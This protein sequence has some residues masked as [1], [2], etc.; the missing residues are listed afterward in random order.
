MSR[1]LTLVI[2]VLIVLCAIAGVAWYKIQ[3]A[4]NR[5]KPRLV[6]YCAT[7]REIVQDLIDR[8]EKESGIHV[9]TKFDTEAAKAVGLVQEIRQE[10]SHPQCDVLWGG[11]AFYNTILANDGCLTAFPTDLIAAHGN[12]PRDPQGRWLG[13][14]GVYRVLIVNTDVLRPEDRPHSIFDLA[15]PKLKGHVG[16]ANPM[17]GA[18][19]AHIA[20]LYSTVGPAKT[21]DWLKGLKANNCALCAGM[22]DVKNRVA[23]GELWCGITSTIDAHVALV[24]G[25]PVVVIYPDQEENQIGCMNGYGAVGRIAGGPHPRETEQFLHFLMTTQTEKILAEGPGQNIGLL[26]QSV[27]E[28]VRPE[29]IPRSIKTMNIDWEKAVA[30]HAESAKA[31]KDILFNE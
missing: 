10:R 2:G 22:A 4:N 25:K 9:D 6:L 13:F 7:D 27:K 8:F 14:A 12:A 17:F 18:M 28:D 31:I 3:Q 11:G 21:R 30:S 24:G 29:W 5:Y 1:R 19:D 16:I 23:S 20:A 26:P 15:D